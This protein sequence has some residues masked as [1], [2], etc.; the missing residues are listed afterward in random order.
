[1]PVVATAVGGVPEVVRDGEN[2][3]L[4]PPGDSTALAN[5]MRRM[6]DDDGLHTRLAAAA[7]PSVAE[8]GREPVYA[9]LEAIL[10]EVGG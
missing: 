7:Q 6:L 1:V 9:R 4:V 5:A 10:Q 3:L 8:I 2:G